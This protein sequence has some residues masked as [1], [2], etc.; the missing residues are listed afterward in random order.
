M[1]IFHVFKYTVLSSDRILDLGQKVGPKTIN[2]VM[3]YFSTDLCIYAWW[4][5]EANSSSSVA[6]LFFTIYHRY[7]KLWKSPKQPPRKIF[8]A[9][10]F[11]FEKLSKALYWSVFLETPSV[12]L[13]NQAVIN[14]E[15]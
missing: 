3:G 12:T 4:W 15:T 11:K 10:L 6:M 14:A 5:G 2:P 9:V 13:G 8:W 1:L 7:Y